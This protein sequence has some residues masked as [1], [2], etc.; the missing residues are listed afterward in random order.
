MRAQC[1]SPVGK[2]SFLRRQKDQHPGRGVLFLPKAVTILSD[3][4]R[5]GRAVSAPHENRLARR[6]GE[7]TCCKSVAPLVR[8]GDPGSLISVVATSGAGRLRRCP[9]SREDG[10]GPQGSA[11]LSRRKARAIRK[12][13]LLEDSL[14]GMLRTVRSENKYTSATERSLSDA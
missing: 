12:R 3:I 11:R 8:M 10:P 2:P 4:G 9:S 1:D 5:A 7:R 13:W 14:S 6:K